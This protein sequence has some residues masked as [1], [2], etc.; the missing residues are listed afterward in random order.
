M[1]FKDMLFQDLKQFLFKLGFKLIPTSGNHLI[2]KHSASQALVILP[3]YKDKSYVERIHLV[4]V[5]RILIEYDLIDKSEIDF[6]F[7][8]VSA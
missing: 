2:F 5:R 3:L 8:K 1:I 7:T 4:T 6:I